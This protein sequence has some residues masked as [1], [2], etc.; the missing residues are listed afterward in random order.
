MLTDRLCTVDERR[1]EPYLSVVA[2]SRNDDHGEELL[3]RMQIFVS[4][5]VSQSIRHTVP[6]E[7][8]LVEWNPPPD[9]PP[10]RDVLTWPDD[11]GWCPV[12][13][14]TVPPALHGSFAYSDRLPLFQMIAKNAGIRRAQGQF[15][16]ATNIDI[17]FSD[18]LMA[19]LA[20]RRLLRGC[21]YRSDRIDVDRSV[22]IQATIDAQLAYC[23]T[24]VLRANRPDGI[25]FAPLDGFPHTV[26]ETTLVEEELRLRGGFGRLAPYQWLRKMLRPT[27]FGR[28]MS[29]LPVWRILKE[30]RR[31]P[32][33]RQG[34]DRHITSAGHPLFAHG[35]ASEHSSYH[36]RSFTNV[37]T[38]LLWPLLLLPDLHLNACG[39]FTLMA[40]ETWFDIGGNPELEVFSLHLDSLVLYNAHAH[41][42]RE[43]RLPTDMVHYHIEHEHGWTPE[44]GRALYER[45]HALGIP[46]MTQGLL[47]KFAHDLGHGHRTRLSGP[48]WG[49][50]N[51]VLPERRVAGGRVFEVLP[52]MGAQA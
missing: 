42:V 13:I 28:L 51:Y 6:S 33:T 30:G 39:D 23:R 19:F 29:R 22:S 41:G 37:I 5:L 3:A 44:S 36:A 18:P 52:T 14:I 35:L 40:R 25:R 4:A 7:L 9:R 48:E 24:H 10:L 45:L 47:A 31:L 17:L 21:L 27:A 34:A 46:C 26:E 43:I 16:L 12:R 38:G 32:P 8:V 11:R 2:T 20:Q 15:V 49:L 50:A 1:G